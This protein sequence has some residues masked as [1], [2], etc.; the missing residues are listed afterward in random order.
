MVEGRREAVTWAPADG[1]TIKRRRLVVS[2]SGIPAVPFFQEWDTNT[3][4]SSGTVKDTRLQGK[5]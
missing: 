4:G 2:I 1:P 5:T 3:W